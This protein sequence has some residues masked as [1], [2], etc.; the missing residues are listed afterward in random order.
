MRQ[1]TPYSSPQYYD[2]A[3]NMFRKLECDFLERCFAKQA[4]GPVR[5][6]LDI[7]CGTG[8]HL[9]RLAKRGYEMTGLDLSAENLAYVK[10]RA[11]QE[12][13]TI[14]LVQADMTDFQLEPHFDAAI[15]LQD[16]QGH[17]LTNEQI[18]SHLR[19]VTR[20]VRPGGL[21]IFDRMIPNNWAHPATR[22]SWT[23]RQ[24]RTTVRTIF[25]TMLDIDEVSQ[26][27]REEITLEVREGKKQKI[28]RHCYPTRVVFPQELRAL[29]QLN[30]QFELVAWHPNFHLHRRLENTKHPLMIVAVLRRL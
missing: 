23:R 13:L 21:Y 22:W 27:C 30:G 18:L 25:R 14:E 16:S 10:D 17:L 3:F 8:P 20:A 7:A 12:G 28:I 26:V 19:A 2:I 15:C 9:I 4:V 1:T 11:S 24:G 5:R 6:V 29:I